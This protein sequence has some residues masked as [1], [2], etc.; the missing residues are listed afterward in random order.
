MRFRD[1]PPKNRDVAMRTSPFFLTR[2]A[3]IPRTSMAVARPARLPSG[4]IAILDDRI[5]KLELGVTEAV[6][7]IN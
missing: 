1:A 5:L 2:Y 4:N 6:S 3:R 7:G